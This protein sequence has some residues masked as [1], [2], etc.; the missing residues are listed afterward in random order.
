MK[1]KLVYVI[2]VIGI[3][4]G[5]VSAYIYNKKI[6]ALPPVSIS[7]NPYSTGIYAEGITESYQTNGEN[8]NI[9]PEVSGRIV[10]ILVKE[11]DFVKKGT[12]L[13]KIDDS[14][15]RYATDQIKAQS[16]AAL[17]LLQELKAEPRNENLTVTES[18]VKYAAA[19]VKAQKDQFNKILSAYRLN[20]ESISK[21]TLD[22]SKDAY[23]EAKANYKVAINQYN[24]VKAG[25]WIYDIRNQKAQYAAL[26][27]SYLS[28]K[29]LLD[30]YTIKAPVS[31]NILLIRT[32]VGDYISPQGSYGTYTQDYGPV[33]V[34]GAGSASIMEVKCYIDEILV[35]K[36]PPSSRMQ[37]VLFV[38]GTNIKIPLEFV[39][40]E[41]YVVPK[42]ELSNQRT[43]KVDV[44]VLPVIFKFEKPKGVNLYPGQLVDVYI[45]EEK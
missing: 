24:L 3:M 6:K 35:S 10:K 18:Q 36:L 41:P 7:Y 13:I 27:K 11:G 22:T 43:E 14:Q 16:R 33:I 21:N 15:Q 9:F 26:S 32:T 44:R 40:I 20:P 34:M 37:A 12:P 31:G 1:N 19:Q 38:R 23:Y 29:S 45:G 5:L 4:A 30:K 25:A 42:I 8:I 2:A 17:V 28:N 39:R